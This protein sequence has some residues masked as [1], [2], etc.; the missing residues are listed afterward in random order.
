MKRFLL[1]LAWTL[2]IYSVTWLSVKLQN[3]YL[4]QYRETSILPN[5]IYMLVLIPFTLGIIIGLPNLIYNI[6]KKSVFRVDWMKILVIC[7][8][9]LFANISLI[10]HVTTNIPLVLPMIVLDTNLPFPT[11]TGMISG[12]V[13]VN[14]MYNPNKENRVI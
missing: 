9:F 2:L 5:G 1:L 3:Y 8:P 11:I 7:I 6:I 10:L 4:L 14:S 12:Y 13:L